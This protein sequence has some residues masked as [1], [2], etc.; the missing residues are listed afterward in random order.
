MEVPNY[1]FTNSVYWVRLRL[2]NRTQQVGEWL[3]KVGFV[4]MHYVDLYTP[5]PDGEG[6]IEKQTGVL[7]PLST[8]DIPDPYILLKLAVPSQSQQT[9]YLRFQNG[10]SMT[11]PLTLWTRDAFYVESQQEK[12]LHWLFFGALMALLV[13]HL[14]LLFSLREAS[15]LF[16]VILLA[17]LIFEELSYN[18]YLEVYFFP[19]LYSLRQIYYPLS[20]AAMIVSMMLFIDAFLELKTRLALLHWVTIGFITFWGVLMLLTPF[21]S[22]HNI[23]NLMAP[24]AVLSLMLVLAAGI[25]SWRQGF[26]SRPILF[27]RLVWFAGFP[28]HGTYG[29][30]C[31][32]NQ[33]DLYGEFLQVRDDMDERVLV[34]RACRPHQPAEI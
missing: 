12:M 18:G 3:L 1:G 31:N 34:D 8:R 14:F 21:V 32:N 13:Y 24:L 22:Y 7:R 33:H 29:P 6:F 15:Y 20:F 11:L 2:D 30:F 25:A 27:D 23:A 16:F 10:A 5:I 28:H 4:N 19:N 26:P 17:S 9:F